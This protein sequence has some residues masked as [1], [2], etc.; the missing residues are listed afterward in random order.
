MRWITRSFHELTVDELYGLLQ[1]RNRVFV[2]EQQAPY[3]DLDGKDKKGHHL[4]LLNNQNEVIACTRLLPRGVSYPEISIGRVVVDPDQR[5][6]GLAHELMRLA[7]SQC[8]ELFGTGSIRISAQKHLAGFYAQ[9]GFRTITE[10]Y[11]EDGIP[12]V[13]MR[14]DPESAAGRDSGKQIIVHYLD[15]SAWLLQTPDRLLLFDYGELPVRQEQGLPAEGVFDPQNLPDLPLY[16]FASHRHRDHYSANLH[17]SLRQNERSNFILGLDAKP[18]ASEIAACPGKTWQ[19]WPGLELVL[20]DLV[21]RCTGSTDSGV[22]FLVDCPEALIYHGGDLAVWDDEAF[23]R[24]NYRQ[25]V[26]QLES[27]IEKI[28]R[29]PAMAF[30]PVSTSDGFQEEALLDGIWH[31]LR[32]IQPARILPMHAHGYE[33]L[34][35]RFAD[36]AKAEGWTNV[37]VPRTPGDCFTIDLA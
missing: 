34:Y 11:L 17:K 7:I 25:Q 20:H 28:E 16:V 22:S 3:L 24:D 4:L 12:H 31:F 14:Y 21:I 27:W 8:R 18:L 5:G 6:Q 37:L 10:E 1:L 13:G 32:K 19:V 35:Q 2:V 15:H 23:Y 26:G 36:L 33:D 9:H 30:L 29:V